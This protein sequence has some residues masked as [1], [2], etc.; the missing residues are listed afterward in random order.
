MI[1]HRRVSEEGKIR[2]SVK[3]KLPIWLPRLFQVLTES[4]GVLNQVFCSRPEVS[5][6]LRGT[7][8]R[9]EVGC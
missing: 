9:E 4:I 7:Q 2:P 3:L 6:R 8:T 1:D 5:R